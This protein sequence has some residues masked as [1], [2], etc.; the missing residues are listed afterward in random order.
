MFYRAFL[1]ALVA[2]PLL[3]TAQ[4]TDDE[5]AE[6]LSDAPQIIYRKV[7]TVDFEKGVEVEGVLLKPSGGIVRG[8]QRAPHR[9]LVRLRTN[10][11][12]ELADSVD[13]VK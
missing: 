8:T 5:D 13:E 7:D 9:S 1:A 6:G 4:T 10:F 12:P 11:R 2:V 3:A